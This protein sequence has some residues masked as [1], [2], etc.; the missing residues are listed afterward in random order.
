M[1]EK[2]KT[3]I[4]KAEV[5]VE[6]IVESIE[7]SIEKVI[8]EVEAAIGCTEAKPREDSLFTAPIEAAT[9]GEL[10]ENGHLIRPEKAPE[11]F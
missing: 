4:K 11:H 5:E 6:T 2:L 9:P 8:E 3:A 10:D 1:K 7:E